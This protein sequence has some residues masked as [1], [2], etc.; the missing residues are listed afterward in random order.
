[1]LVILRQH[2]H[3]RQEWLFAYPNR[4]FLLK[5]LTKHSSGALTQHGTSKRQLTCHYST[6]PILWA[7]WPW[8]SCWMTGAIWKLSCFRKLNQIEEIWKNFFPPVA[9]GS[10]EPLRIGLH[11]RTCIF[12]NL[13]T[14]IRVDKVCGF[15]PSKIA[16]WF[17]T[18]RWNSPLSTFGIHS[19][20]CQW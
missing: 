6:N 9:F 1:M 5:T 16:V 8:L 4:S 20:M 19:V 18:K 2:R 10:S 13:P 12:F 3:T 7:A 14:R 15:L 17:L 11:G